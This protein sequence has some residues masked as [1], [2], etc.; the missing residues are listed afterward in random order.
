MLPFEGN[1][2]LFSFT[3]VAEVPLPA[4][5]APIFEF[6]DQLPFRASDHDSDVDMSPVRDSKSFFSILFFRDALKVSDFK[7]IR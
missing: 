1:L 7:P 6:N 2:P 5:P 3:P 4:I